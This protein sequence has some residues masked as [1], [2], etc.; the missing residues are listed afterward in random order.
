[1]KGA[2]IEAGNSGASQI[3]V[4]FG[5]GCGV[6]CGLRKR[7]VRFEVA[8]ACCG[9]VV[10]VWLRRSPDPSR[11]KYCRECQRRIDVASGRLV[12]QEKA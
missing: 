4:T 1:V 2:H 7:P 8:C 11:A 6:W 5:D 9:A 3:F 10:V 12:R